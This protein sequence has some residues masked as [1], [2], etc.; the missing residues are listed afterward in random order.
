[1]HFTTDLCSE[2]LQVQGQLQ[3]PRVPHR[4]GECAA[5]RRGAVVV[6]DGVVRVGHRQGH[7]QEEGHPGLSGVPERRNR[8]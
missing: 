5:R 4:S 2:C 3:S 8:R 7:G 1:M 6:R